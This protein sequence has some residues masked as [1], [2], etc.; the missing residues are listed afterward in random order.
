MVQEL[1]AEIVKTL[2]SYNECTGILTWLSSGNGKNARQEAGGIHKYDGYKILCIYG[3]QYKYHRVAWLLHYGEWPKQV[4]DHINGDKLDNRICNLRDVSVKINRQN[5]RVPG[6][7]NK[8][9]FLGVSKSKNEKKWRA[10][11]R[12]NDKQVEIGRFTNPEEA[13]Q[14]YL[15]AKRQ[16]HAGCTI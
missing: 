5:S 4:I 9:G 15:V 11:I 2:L 8:S 1:T 10:H 12:I 14:A 7:K 16:Y 13:H 3:K 6:K